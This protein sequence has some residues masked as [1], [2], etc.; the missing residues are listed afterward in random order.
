MPNVCA[1]IYS[2]FYDASVMNNISLTS[3]RCLPHEGEIAL[4]TPAQ[5]LVLL[6]Q[7]PGWRAE[8]TFIERSFSFKD[9]YQAIAFVN[10]VAWIS[11]AE[12]HH[13]EISIGYADV[14]I[15]YWTHAVAGLSEHD[16]ICAAK[17]DALPLSQSL[18]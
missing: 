3:R 2:P 13:P 6:Q 15:R 9:H 7:L 12:N 11:H 10:A 1:A 8:E 14:R 17:V 16:F 4:L 5:C 18:R